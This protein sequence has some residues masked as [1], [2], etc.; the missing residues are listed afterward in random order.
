MRE[1]IDEW[2]LDFCGIKGQPEMTNSCCTMDIAEAFVNDTYD[3]DGPK[4]TMI[5]S[6]E[7][8]IDAA[9]TMKLMKHISGTPVLFA[10]VRHYHGDLDV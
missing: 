4:E 10:D 2:S 8:D 1:L 5:C 6:T 9:L 7:S 3:C